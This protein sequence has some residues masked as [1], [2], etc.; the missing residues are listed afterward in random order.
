MVAIIDFGSQYTNLILRRLRQLCV[1]AEIFPP[2]FTFQKRN[3]I[4]GIILSGGPQS[5]YDRNSLT[6]PKANLNLD[7]PILGICYGHQFLAKALGGQVRV[8][9]NR[10]YG[11]ETIEI[12]N[13]S[14]LF[15]G[16]GKKQ[17]VWF[18]H[19]DQVTKLP[20]GFKA[21]ATSK[22]CSIAAFERNR[23][24]GLQ[25]H[26]EVIHTEN[27]LKILENF[28]SLCAVTKDWS[29]KDQVTS[30]VN[31]IKEEIGGEKV[32]I[33]VSGGVDSLVVATLIRTAIGDRI[34]PVFVDS[35]LLR[36][37]EAEEV[38]SLFARLKFGN[39]SFIDAS[40]LFLTRLKGVSDPERKR[41]IIG[42]IFIGVFTKEG[43]RLGKK[44]KV[45]FL[46][47]GTIYPDRIESASASK[48][49]S[50]IK[51]HHNLAIPKSIKFK[52]LE[53]LK[54]LYKDEVRE[55]GRS[56]GLQ[57]ERLWRHPFPGPGL[58]IRILDGVT[59]ERLTILRKAD[60]IYIEELTTSGLYDEI[61]QAFAALLPVKSVGVMGDARTYQYIVSLRA[62]T[63]HDGMTADWF[64]MPASVL[65]KI[66]SRI[67]NEVK[68]VNRV[69]YDITQ[70]P[71]ATIE[72]E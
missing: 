37:G 48:Q 33:A 22:S 59:K 68:G 10:E 54:D 64:K 38:K 31:E 24:F 35:G 3:N 41:K 67:V 51:S 56:L 52:I 50:K 47:Q 25:F 69:V 58:A 21:T 13:K 1:R 55:L 14:P 70:K 53:P 71:P 34:Y 32:L 26:P 15:S 28:V 62:V 9:D 44:E 8:G 46:A 12:T 72:Y 7:V 49:A 40:K 57:K 65:E 19:G 27:G 43:N 42:K 6:T 16:L 18:S 30:L 2:N 39:F 63:S 45:Q 36:E 66:S 17:N 11:R 60:A 23:I 4:K 61:W 29:I 5:V 20:V